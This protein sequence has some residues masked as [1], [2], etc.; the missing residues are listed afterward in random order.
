MTHR[1]CRTF[2]ASLS[3]VALVLAAS[4][5][6]ANPGVTHVGG[7]APPHPASPPPAG[8]PMH[9]QRGTRGFGPIVDGYFYGPSYDAPMA[10]VTP[11]RSSTISI[12]PARTI[13]PGTMCIDVRS[14][15]HLANSFRCPTR[16]GKC[17][18]KRGRP[19]SLALIA[20]QQADSDKVCFRGKTGSSGRSSRLTRLRAGT[21]ARRQFNAVSTARAP[22]W[23][24]H[25]QRRPL[26]GFSS[27]PPG[28]GSKF[29]WPPRTLQGGICSG[30]SPCHRGPLWRRH[31]R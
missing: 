21:P 9:H 19:L 13:F 4:A 30:R 7:V 18:P 11:S 28:H 27:R 8:R 6:L 29:C 17:V 22:R 31:R 2:I 3:A 12:T 15:S 16:V 5:A 14:L 10:D 25:N 24:R 20:R 1:M 26:S 23:C